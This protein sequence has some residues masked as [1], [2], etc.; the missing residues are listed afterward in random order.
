MKGMSQSLHFGKSVAD[1]GWGM[2]TTFLHY[3]LVKQGKH[4]IKINKWF[5]QLKPAQIADM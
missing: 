2:F 5:L 4:L 3:K 1:N